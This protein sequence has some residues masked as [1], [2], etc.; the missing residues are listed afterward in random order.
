LI[1]FHLP[2]LKHLDLSNCSN[3]NAGSV[4]GL[5]HLKDLTSLDVRGTKAG[6]RDGVEQLAK[7][8]SCR[9]LALSLMPQEQQQQQ[10]PQQQQQPP[11][12]PPPQQQQQRKEGATTLEGTGGSVPA[13]AAAA[14]VDASRVAGA[15]ASSSSRGSGNAQRA[16][17]LQQL[18]QHLGHSRIS[19]G[20]P[21]DSPPPAAAAAASG[22]PEHQHAHRLLYHYQQQQQQ[23]QQHLVP[24]QQVQQ[25]PQRRRS[26]IDGHSSISMP[27]SLEDYAYLAVLGKCH[28]LRQLVLGAGPAVAE[29]CRQLLP[30]W[31]EV[32]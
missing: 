29:Y 10:P 2:A 9:R 30:P 11:P 22:P 6:D 32:R 25:Q 13:G 26:S 1:F 3:F 27:S 28:S 18:V 14:Q 8:R 12:P 23:Q 17:V 31:V 15:A 21:Q 5:L 20:Q 16:S 4:A 7:L 19:H 24:H